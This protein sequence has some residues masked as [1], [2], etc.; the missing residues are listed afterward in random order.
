MYTMRKNGMVGALEENEFDKTIHMHFS[1]WWSGEG[2]DFDVERV[3]HKGQSENCKY[4][5]SIAE[6]N[7]VASVMLACGMIDL[8]DVKEKADQLIHQ[9]KLDE[10]RIHESHIEGNGRNLWD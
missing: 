2:M 5:L 4:S 1:E 10:V 7:M 9:C 6:M 8:D 3:G